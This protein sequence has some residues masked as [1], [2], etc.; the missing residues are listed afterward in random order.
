M[1][2]KDRS[3]LKAN[4]VAGDELGCGGGYPSAAPPDTQG[5]PK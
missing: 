2:V 4:G 5:H 1:V 3:I